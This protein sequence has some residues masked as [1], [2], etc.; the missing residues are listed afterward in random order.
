MIRT[1][2]VERER[3]KGS[4]LCKSLLTNKQTKENALNES[5]PTDTCHGE[6]QVSVRHL[7]LTDHVKLWIREHFSGNLRYLGR[8][9]P[10]PPSQNPRG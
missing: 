3:G 6:D 10:L 2:K 7:L 4:L 5:V 1:K 9:H 8:S